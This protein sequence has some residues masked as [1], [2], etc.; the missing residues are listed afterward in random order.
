[1]NLKEGD[2]LTNDEVLYATMGQSPERFS[3]LGEV[4]VSINDD[5]IIKSIKPLNGERTRIWDDIRTTGYP[6]VL[7]PYI[8]N[9][10]Y[11][12]EEYKNEILS[13]LDEVAYEY[14][15]TQPC[16]LELVNAIMTG[17]TNEFMSAALG[18]DSIDCTSNKSKR[19]WLE[20][21][22]KGDK[23]PWFKRIQI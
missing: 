1:M 10:I 8:Y 20:I 16:Y 4:E 13:I 7:I 3:Y 23:Y 6:P 15:T 19:T 22:K 2:F 12:N 5:N 21:V 18:C 14:F 17:M 9:A 11:V